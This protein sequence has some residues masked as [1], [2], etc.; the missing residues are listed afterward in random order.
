[1]NFGLCGKRDLI[2]KN[3]DKK[4]GEVR[5]L[6]GEAYALVYQGRGR[7]F[8]KECGVTPYFYHFRSLLSAHGS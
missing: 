1:M 6:P 3:K 7:A 5:L 2:L 8:S 4:G